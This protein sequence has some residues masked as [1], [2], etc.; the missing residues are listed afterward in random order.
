M[1]LSTIRMV[2]NRVARERE[3]SGKGLIYARAS[4]TK[5]ETAPDMI[6]GGH[7]DNRILECAVE[8]SADYLV[9]GARRHLLPIEEHQG[10]RIV[11]APRFRSALER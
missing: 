1:K 10:M 5:T 3:G 8:A 9:T 11:N 2:R 4:L 7:G 6:G